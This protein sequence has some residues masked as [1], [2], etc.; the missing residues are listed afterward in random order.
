MRLAMEAAADGRSTRQLASAMGHP[1]SSVYRWRNVDREMPLGAAGDMARALGLELVVVR[2][3][4]ARLAPC[5]HKVPLPRDAVTPR[6][7]RVTCTQCG[8]PYEWTMVEVEG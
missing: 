5:G 8:T 1:P 3:G 7:L 4:Q 2:L 6:D